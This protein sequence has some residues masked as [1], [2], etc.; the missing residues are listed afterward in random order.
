VRAGEDHETGP[1][2]VSTEFF[3]YGPI[4]GWRNRN[5]VLDSGI[6]WQKDPPQGVADSLT[7][8]LGQ[9]ANGCGIGVESLRKDA[10]LIPIGAK[11]TA[12]QTQRVRSGEM[13]LITV[14]ISCE[15][16]KTRPAS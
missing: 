8:A 2:S 4:A 6:N 3:Y 15:S 9:L 1:D 11:L 12:A 16:D 13:Q 7:I 5:P 10:E 14:G